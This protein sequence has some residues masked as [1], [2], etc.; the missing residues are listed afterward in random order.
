[1]MQAVTEK[2]LNHW[3]NT[4][5]NVNHE[6]LS[7]F[8][9]ILLQDGTSFGL[10]GQLQEAYPGRFTAT[11]PAAAEIHVTYNLTHGTIEKSVLTPDSYSER[12]ELPEAKILN[13]KLLLADRGYYSGKLLSEIDEAGGSYVLRAMRL[14]KIP[15]YQAIRED[16]KTI[17]QSNKGKAL[18]DIIKTQKHHKIIDM[19]VEIEQKRMRL[20]AIY[21]P[22]EK[23]YT[24]LVTNLKTA[25]FTVEE[26]IQLYRLR[27]QV[28]LLFKECK[29]YNNLQGYQTG[30]ATLQEAMIWGSLIAVT[31]KR[32]ITKSIEQFY[33]LEMSTMIVSKTTVHWWY[34]LLESIVGNKRK[35]LGKVLEQT[36]RFLKENASRA[37]PKRDR[38]TG[39]YQ[40]GVEPNFLAK[41]TGITA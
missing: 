3:V 15:V 13:K 35:Q 17:Y 8:E 5:L 39:I 36:Y 16:G 28:E 25:D 37:N 10:N 40:F 6:V 32:F 9:Q 29:S 30:N 23:R 18:S 1:M 41:N 34:A 22:K 7:R 24:Y 31:L 11:S 14:S 2:V 38:L 20:V 19:Q 21:S 26:I 4:H 27:W 33:E 12:A